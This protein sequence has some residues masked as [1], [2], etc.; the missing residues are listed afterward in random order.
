[1]E[2]EDLRALRDHH[3]GWRLLLA[4]S[5]PM[6]VAFLHRVFLAPNV[7]VLAAP[8]LENQLE[9]F[10][11][12]L[13]VREGDQA[14][15]RRA[16]DY[17]N[18]WAADERG[19]LRKYYPA[20]SDEAHYDLTPATEAAIQWLLHLDQPHFVGAESR[21]SLVFDL[22]E[23]IVQGAETDPE[24]RL[25][26][27]QAQRAALDAEIEALRDGHLRLMDPTRLRERFLQMASTARGLLAD[28][29]Q[30]EA[31]F[32]ALDR[33]VREQI[34]TW[35]GGK[36]AV[37]DQVF[38]E[39]D[40][41]VDSDQ[42]RSFR[43]FW[44]LL[45]SPAR[46]ETLADLLD[47]ALELP[48]VAELQPDRGLRRIHYDWLQAGEHTQREVARLSEQLRRYLDDQA[49]LENRRIMDL[50]REVEQHALAVR[51]APPPTPV[52]TLDEP[53]P[54]IELPMERPLFSPPLK[55]HIDQTVVEA[56]QSDVATDALFEQ[57][58]VD[59]AELQARLRRAL[60]TR[61]QITLQE[62]L[63]ETPLERGLAELVVWMA[64]AAE[65]PEHLINEARE[66]VIRWQ[67]ET[68]GWRQARMPEVIFTR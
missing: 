52:M 9:D 54:R 64:I 57:A 23:Q 68:G 32:R 30:V 37:L 63:Q 38:G 33:E 28:F 61:R 43:A 19:W 20:N 17:L 5:A 2:F 15:P 4:D 36:G 50:I 8:E 49:W 46:Q 6:V 66:Q 40:R 59:R 45:M 14:F 1:M 18:D 11:H 22:L 47:R 48:A 24:A 39:Q 65:A 16:R 27:L 56:G 26:D 13:R 10:L 51:Q 62:L 34:A 67:D 21:L 44:E 58:W 3:P 60:Q 7:R 25:Q 55:P 31:N 41:I 12:A 53:A 29:R 42:G 35:E